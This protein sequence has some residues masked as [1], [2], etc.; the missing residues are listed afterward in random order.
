MCIRWFVYLVCMCAYVYGCGKSFH[1]EFNNNNNNN[2][3]GN[4]YS[5]HIHSRSAQ[6]AVHNY[7]HP[8]SLDPVTIPHGI[9]RAQAQLPWGAY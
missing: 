8:R 4:F 5:T 2:N 7:Y 9:T 1:D 3:N 6:G